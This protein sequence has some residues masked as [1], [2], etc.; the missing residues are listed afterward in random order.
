MD[1]NTDKSGHEHREWTQAQRVDTKKR[2]DTNMEWTKITVDI[3]TES[4]HK[5]R[6][7]TNTEI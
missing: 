3:N 6:V 5:Y 2:L 7:D 1:T 4:G